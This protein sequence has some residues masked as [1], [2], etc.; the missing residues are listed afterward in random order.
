MGGRV[1]QN[2][3]KYVWSALDVFQDY[4][5]VMK[6]TV[7]VFKTKIIIFTNEEINHN[8]SFM[9]ESQ[10]IEI[11]SEYKYLGIYFSKNGSFT[12]AKKKIAEQANKAVFALLRK[13]KDLDLPYDLQLD[14]FDKTIKPILLYGSEV[15]GIGNCDIIE[16]VHLKFIKYIFKLKTSTPSHMIYGELG[17]IPI[18]TEIQA[19]IV[20]FWSKLIEYQEN[21]K[22]SSEVYSVIYA[23]YDNKQLKSKWLENIKR[24]LCSLGFSGIWDAQS[25]T[26]SKWLIQAVKQK[27]K[28]VYSQTW[29]S[30]L[31]KSSSSNSNYK[32]FKHTFERSKYI[33]LTTSYMCR[34]FLAFRTRN[35]RFPVEVGR[36]KHRRKEHHERK[37][38]FCDTD[39]GDEYH[40]LLICNKFSVERRRFLKPYY[41]VHPNI[42]KFSDLMNTTN[43]QILKKLCMFVDILLKSF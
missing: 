11:V 22:L 38:N 2:V 34:R 13:I 5:N 1:I 16:R 36:W 37:C 42:L 41:Y 18:T 28:D 24:I 9:F 20:S 40:Y 23:L 43:L 19:R 14:I 4:C 6:L 8:L 35:H 31:E 10:P 7:N 26:N 15:W 30:K 3:S 25:F 29:N 32:L 21:I 39:I 27:I 12:L 17:I 33:T